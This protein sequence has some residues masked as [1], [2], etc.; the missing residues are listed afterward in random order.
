MQGGFNMG[1]GQRNL[2][3]KRF[4][5]MVDLVRHYYGI[6]GPQYW[7]KQVV[8]VSECQKKVVVDLKALEGW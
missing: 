1:C 5:Q 2:E 3:S 7:E 4:L 8:R 6:V